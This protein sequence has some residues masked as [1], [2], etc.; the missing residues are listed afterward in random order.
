M[1]YKVKSLLFFIAF[2]LSAVIYYAVDLASLEEIN[3][4]RT[5]ITDLETEEDI[6]AHEDE[7]V[8]FLE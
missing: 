6:P 4:T 8:S 5:E 3:P 1:N 2:V 7:T